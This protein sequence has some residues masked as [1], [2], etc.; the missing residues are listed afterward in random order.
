MRI[1]Q[2]WPLLIT[3][4]FD[5]YLASLNSSQLKKSLDV[6]IELKSS[7]FFRSGI[8]Q[9]L[10]RWQKYVEIEGDYFEVIWINFFINK[11]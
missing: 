11:P 6:F 9:I 5:P 4:Y 8:R 3:T 1:L 2:T 7:L 10:K